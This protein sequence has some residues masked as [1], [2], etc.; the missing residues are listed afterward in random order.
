MLGNPREE[1]WEFIDK[2]RGA[3]SFSTV[4]NNTASCPKWFPYDPEISPFN[5]EYY[6]SLMME[7][8]GKDHP[9]WK[10]RIDDALSEY[11]DEKTNYRIKA[12]ERRIDEIEKRLNQMEEK[13]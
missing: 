9:E 2:Y 6:V 12:L 5:S 3:S 7:N 11:V 4:P 1:D 13:T 10:S 8:Y